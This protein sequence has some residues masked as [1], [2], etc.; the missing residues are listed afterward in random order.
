MVVKESAE[1]YSG[2]PGYMDIVMGGTFHRQ[3]FVLFGD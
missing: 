2:I 3:I 1:A